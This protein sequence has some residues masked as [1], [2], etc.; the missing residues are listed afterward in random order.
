MSLVS[1][2]R[3]LIVFSRYVIHVEWYISTIRLMFDNC[4]CKRK[5]CDILKYIMTFFASWT[6]SNLDAKI[7]QNN[8]FTTKDL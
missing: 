3:Q 6:L 5:E 8:A 4:N 2:K 1:N 7:E